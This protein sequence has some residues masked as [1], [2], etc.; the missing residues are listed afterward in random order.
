[1]SVADFKQSC[2][3]LSDRFEKID[4]RGHSIANLSKSWGHRNNRN[5]DVWL[6]C[7]RLGIP[8]SSR[9]MAQIEPNSVDQSKRLIVACSEVKYCLHSTKTK[10]GV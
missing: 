6:P 8:C 5:D 1:M 7:C 9:I 3:F 2:I 10:T 4:R